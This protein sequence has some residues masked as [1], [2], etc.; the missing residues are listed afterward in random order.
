[1]KPAEMSRG[2]G[3]RRYPKAERALSATR[4]GWAALTETVLSLD[5]VGGAQF[6]LPGG[7]LEGV[8][9]DV[10]AERV[11]FSGL[12]ARQERLM[13]AHIDALSARL[14]RPVRLS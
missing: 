8:R 1:M 3:R 6:E 10:S 2:A 4:G 11:R 13:R 14:G 5:E 12:S 9:V 7:V